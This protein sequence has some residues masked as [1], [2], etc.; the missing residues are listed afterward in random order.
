MLVVVKIRTVHFRK[1]WKELNF[2]N[3]QKTGQLSHRVLVGGVRA[4]NYVSIIF[5]NPLSYHAVSHSLLV[6]VSR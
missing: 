3:K 2:K 6:D 1:S 5:I 4:Q